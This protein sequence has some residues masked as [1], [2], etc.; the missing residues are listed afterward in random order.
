[1]NYDINIAV[2][3]VGFK[4]EIPLTLPCAVNLM[5]LLIKLV[6]TWRTFAIK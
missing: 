4:I 1:M 2:V 3:I 5:A 6:S